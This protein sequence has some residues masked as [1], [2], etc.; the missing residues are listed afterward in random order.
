MFVSKFIQTNTTII[1]KN[2]NL[3]PGSKSMSS[4]LGC[5]S[6]KNRLKCALVSKIQN[7][8]LI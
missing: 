7:I 5:H 2:F 1:L 4:A 6:P 3:E 8:A